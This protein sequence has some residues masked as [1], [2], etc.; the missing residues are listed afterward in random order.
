M[1]IYNAK[2][3]REEN[4]WEQ[5]VADFA[6]NRGGDGTLEKPTIGSKE[7][8]ENQLLR[9]RGLIARIDHLGIVKTS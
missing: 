6:R 2:T 3:Q 8:M 1:Y 7:K 5:P 9:T 4:N